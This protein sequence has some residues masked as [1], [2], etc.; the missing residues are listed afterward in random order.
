MKLRE[1][2]QNDCK[3]TLNLFYDTVHSVAS[4]DYA[5][6]QLDAWAPKNTDLSY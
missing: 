1:Y 3:E 5:G 6:S 2:H 4:A